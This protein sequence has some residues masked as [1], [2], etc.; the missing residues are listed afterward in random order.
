MNL[1][2]ILMLFLIII[3]HNNLIKLRKKDINITIRL[4]QILDIKKKFKNNQ[5]RYDSFEIN[6]LSTTKLA[7]NKLFSQ[8][9]KNALIDY[10]NTNIDDNHSSITNNIQSYNDFNTSYF[11]LN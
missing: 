1:F 11:T 4:P 7:I 9:M 3:I 2:F 10:V 6:K 5:N 8:D